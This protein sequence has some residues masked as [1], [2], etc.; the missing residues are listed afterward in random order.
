[1]II[2]IIFCISRYTGLRSV[3]LHFPSF[4]NVDLKLFSQLIC[5]IIF[6]GSCS[7][8]NV[9]NLDDIFHVWTNATA[10]VQITVPSP[11]TICTLYCL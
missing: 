9:L 2:R 3:I 7:G 5:C 6:P 8:A 11:R 4:L 10:I 1:M